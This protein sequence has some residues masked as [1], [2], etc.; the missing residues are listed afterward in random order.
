M[1]CFSNMN[2]HLRKNIEE[3]PIR[4]INMLDNQES[5][6]KELDPPKGVDLSGYRAV[7][8]PLTELLKNV[9][10]DYRAVIDEGNYCTHFIPVGKYCHEAAKRLTATQQVLDI[11]VEALNKVLLA[12]K[13][14]DSEI[15]DSDLDNEQPK[16][17]SLTL[18]DIRNIHKL[19]RP[20]INAKF[21]ADSDKLPPLGK[22]L[23]WG[24]RPRQG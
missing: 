24:L 7:Q 9:P 11:A 1:N 18:G 5:E 8:V 20:M 22:K 13:K 3:W 4:G 2:I 6:S 10:I 16:N 12:Y 21:F 17:I 19:I 14:L 23:P 15:S